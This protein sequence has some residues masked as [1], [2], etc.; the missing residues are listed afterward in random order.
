MIMPMQ[1]NSGTGCGLA[2][3]QEGPMRDGQWH[4]ET[5]Q[6]MGDTYDAIWQDGFWKG[7][8]VTLA[9]CVGLWLLS[10]L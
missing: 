5:R 9:V 7:I 1:A 2:S 4:K 6:A 3:C 10:V 8:G